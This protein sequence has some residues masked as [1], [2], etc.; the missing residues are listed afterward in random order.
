MDVLTAGHVIVLTVNV[1]IVAVKVVN[2]KQPNLQK[3]W[4]LFCIFIYQNHYE[5]NKRHTN[6]IDFRRSLD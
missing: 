4:V 1:Q 6:I 5:N 2:K 3:G